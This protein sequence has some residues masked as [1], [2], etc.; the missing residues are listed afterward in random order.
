[1]LVTQA[2]YLPRALYLANELGLDAVGV[3]SDLKLK[4]EV[5]YQSVREMAAEVKAFFN[6][7]ISPPETLLGEHIPIK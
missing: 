7:R 2:F 1:M 4:Q 3:A 6:L 5:D